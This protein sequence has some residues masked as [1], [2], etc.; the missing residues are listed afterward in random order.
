MKSRAGGSYMLRGDKPVR[1][2]H[3][4]SGQQVNVPDELPKDTNEPVAKQGKPRNEQKETDN[5]HTQADAT[6][7][8]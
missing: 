1:V 4:G 6:G 2:A 3:S 7:S 5:A 8:A